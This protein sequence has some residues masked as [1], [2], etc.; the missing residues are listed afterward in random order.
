MN[1]GPD[2][3][4]TVVPLFFVMKKKKKPVTYYN[5]VS[6]RYVFNSLRTNENKHKAI[7]DFNNTCYEDEFIAG[8]YLFM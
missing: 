6:H 8:F 4:L 1:F 7:S 2:S 5:S 3:E